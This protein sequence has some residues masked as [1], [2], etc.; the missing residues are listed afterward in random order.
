MRMDWIHLGRKKERMRG[1]ERGVGACRPSSDRLQC[2]NLP[3][4]YRFTLYI[5]TNYVYDKCSPRSYARKY[6]IH[7]YS[8]ISYFH[9]KYDVLTVHCATKQYALSPRFGAGGPPCV[10][11]FR[12]FFAPETSSSRRQY[13]SPTFSFLSSST[14]FPYSCV[15][16]PIPI[17]PP[18]PP[19]PSLNKH[20]AK[21]IESTQKHPQYQYAPFFAYT[22][23]QIQ[24]SQP[25]QLVG[26][27]PRYPLRAQVANAAHIFVRVGRR[28]SVCAQGP[29]DKDVQERP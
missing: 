5:N 8:F 23:A 18:S 29:P 7:S 4:A 9:F 11:I 1:F 21:F 16:R 10:S 19:I 22:S 20:A 28:H 24:P 25:P 12:L 6:N 3:A 26:Q 27:L 13:S 17:H 2:L 14:S 15:S